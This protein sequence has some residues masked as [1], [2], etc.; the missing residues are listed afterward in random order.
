MGT[1]Q[2]SYSQEAAASP[3][4]RR[5][6]SG[7]AASDLDSEQPRGVRGI[8]Y[9]DGRTAYPELGI[10]CAAGESL[11]QAIDRKKREMVAELFRQAVIPAALSGWDFDSFPVDGAKQAAYDAAR[12][13]AQEIRRDNLLLI[14]ATGTG[15][16]GLAVCI[17]KVRL[18]Q[19]VPSLFVSVPDLL[20]KIRCTFSGHGDYAD[21][22]EAIKAI[23]FL[24]LDD[25]GAHYATPWAS[26]KLFQVLGHRH[27]WQLPT[28]ITSDRPLSELEAVIG[29]RTLAR[30]IEHGQAREVLGRDL[31]RGS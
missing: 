16:T 1:G 30:I 2:A 22:M 3:A 17:L 19:A 6:N 14:G 20:D 12:A 5:P 4:L 9:P 13:Y 18:E 10:L 21:L 24:V 25:L 11:K 31:R 27:D 28:V 7:S 8:H 23:D 15:K 26:E 29:R